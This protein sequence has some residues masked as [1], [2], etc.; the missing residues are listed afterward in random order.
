MTTLTADRARELFLYDPSTGQL[1][2]RIKP[3]RGIKTGT[4]AGWSDRLG[5][6]RV[7]VD[8][9]NYMVHRVAW[10]YTYG[11]WPAGEVDHINGNPSDNRIGNLRDV[12]RAKNQ[13]N[14]VAA[15]KTN[16][17]GLRG[18]F[19]HSN[20]TWIVRIRANGASY[21]LGTFDDPEEAHIAYMQAK[22]CLHI[23]GR[24]P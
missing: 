24:L 7:I 2:Y 18:V 10:L 4:I 6:R 19:R 20:S 9:R 22:M 21:Y 3:R 8:G 1:S 5:Y 13:Q 15:R 11:T 17:S 16:Q 12:D 14:I 23:G